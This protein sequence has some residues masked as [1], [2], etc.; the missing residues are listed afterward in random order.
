MAPVMSVNVLLAWQYACAL[1]NLAVGISFEM[2]SEGFMFG[3]KLRRCRQVMYRSKDDISVFD[4]TAMGI[5]GNMIVFGQLSGE[6][7]EDGLGPT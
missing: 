7:H 5:N 1:W 6:G 2:R 3:L 4:A